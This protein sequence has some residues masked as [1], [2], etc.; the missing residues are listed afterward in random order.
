MTW[1]KRCD[2]VVH[3]KE[4]ATVRLRSWNRN[5]IG[6]EGELCDY[7]GDV[8]KCMVMYPWAVIDRIEQETVFPERKQAA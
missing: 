7:R 6:V 8:Q 1:D 5:T 4:G 3:L 2:I